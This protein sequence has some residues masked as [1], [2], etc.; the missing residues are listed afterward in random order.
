MGRDPEIPRSRDSQLAIGHVNFSPRSSPQR[1]SIAGLSADQHLAAAL[2]LRA[3]ELFLDLG[4]LDD[5]RPLLEALELS[6][7]DATN[8]S[9]VC[10]RARLLHLEER[11]DE[12]CD[13]LR[14]GAAEL[15]AESP[16]DAARLLLESLAA[17]VR[18]RC[19][20]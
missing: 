13:L 11:D 14:Q 18:E 5:A 2:R 17:L 15:A 6:T 20:D 1:H 12:A 4:L 10:T 8:A 19:L 16:D 9:A 7:G 3:A